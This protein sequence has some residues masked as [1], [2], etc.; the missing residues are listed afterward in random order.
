[1]SGRVDTIKYGGVAEYATVP[2]RLKKFRETHPRASIST[3][4]TFLE[5]GSCVFIATIVSDLSDEASARATGSARYT[6]SEIAKPKAFEKLETIAT[7]RALS[8]LGFLNNGEIASS[9]EMLEFELHKENRVLEAIEA[10]KTAKNRSELVAIQ[11]SLP[12][13]DQKQ[14]NEHIRTRIKELTSAVAN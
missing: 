11:A 7:G 2:A 5:D 1:M 8:L 13:D 3:K 10:V 14:L 12:A 9:E 4:P 6:A